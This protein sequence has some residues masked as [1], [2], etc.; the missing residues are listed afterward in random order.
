MSESRR[1]ARERESSRPAIPSPAAFGLI[2][3][4]EPACCEL[5]HDRSRNNLRA[6]YGDLA[7]QARHIDVAVDRVRLSSINLSHEEL[8]SVE[9]LRV[10][11]TE[12]SAATLKFEAEAILADPRRSDN[13]RV[14]MRLLAEGRL[15]VRSA[16]LFDWAP[17]FSIF[18]S[19]GRDDTLLV[20][21]HWFQIPYPS[22]GPALAVLH[23]DAQVGRVRL[24][25]QEMWDLAHDI[26][27][28]V[29]SVFEAAARAT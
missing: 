24:R 4:M 23:R 5:I 1:Q 22:R 26:G 28:A 17:N 14:V 15:R 13:L 19:P 29:R 2:Y 12:I 3:T 21:A 20:G 27:P 25:F 8:G 16:P 7:R 11:V 9:G 18:V 6:I 10:L